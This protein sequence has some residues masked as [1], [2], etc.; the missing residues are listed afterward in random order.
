[1]PNRILKESI[2]TSDNIDQL[3]PWAEIA[4][5]RLIVN[6]DDFGRLDA[7][8]KILKAR[9][10]PLKEASE[11]DIQSWMRE[12]E[13]ADLIQ[14][15]HVDGKPFLQMKT[16]ES[17]QQVRNHKS[18]YPSPEESNCNQLKSNDINCNQMISDDINCT[19]NPIQS[20]PYPNPNPNRNPDQMIADDDAHQIQSEQNRVLDAAEDAGFKMSNNVRASLIALYADSGLEKVLE[21]IK[22]CSEH[23]AVNLAYLRAV[24][25]GEPKKQK[26]KVIGQD[27]DQRDYSSVNDDM[28][29]S[30]A[31]EV[32]EFRKGVS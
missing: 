13:E 26:P 7:R 23:G 25:K 3:S 9:L 1:M 2:C 22:S 5:Y 10:F 20:N 29:S 24:L 19:R 16:W 8:P 18:K 17:H 14:I 11:E 6:C 27:F 4:F 21:G 15:Y 30:L 31:K 32:A 28:M 12:L